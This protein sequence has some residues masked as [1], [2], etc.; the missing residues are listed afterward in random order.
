MIKI[1]LLS[2]AGFV[3]IVLIG[4]FVDTFLGVVYYSRLDDDEQKLRT[5]GENISDDLYNSQN[6][7]DVLKNYNL[8]DIMQTMFFADDNSEIKI[9]ITDSVILI[10]LKNPRE[11]KI[12]RSRTISP[13]MVRRR[14]IPHC[15]FFIVD[16]SDD[17]KKSSYAI[18]DYGSVDESIVP[19]QG[20]YQLV[21]F[22]S[23]PDRYK[24]DLVFD[25][26]SNIEWNELY[27][28]YQ[29]F[30]LYY[31]SPSGN[32]IEELRDKVEDVFSGYVTIGERDIIGVY[33]TEDEV[34]HLYSITKGE[35]C[36]E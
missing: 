35:E 17:P 27:D 20:F 4:N 25:G 13:Q 9:Q 24:F 16:D 18:T 3:V 34:V 15:L 1:V 31:E 12:K 19:F 7:D 14:P 5:L 30:T 33:I 29:L 23:N 32:D 28:I 22:A 2:A 11:S 8:D 21:G 6:K 10:E 36:E 26:I